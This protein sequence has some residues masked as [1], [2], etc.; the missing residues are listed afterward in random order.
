[1]P[2][3][4]AGRD[5][6]FA[7]DGE[8][9][10]SAE[11]GGAGAGA[12]GGCLPNAT[13][14]LSCS[15]TVG[16][17][18]IACKGI[19]DQCSNAL[20]CP[21]HACIE[22]VRAAVSLGS[23]RLAL[24]AP[25]GGEELRVFRLSKSQGPAVTVGSL[26]LYDWSRAYIVVDPACLDDYLL[27]RFP[28]IPRPNGCGAVGCDL[29]FD[30]PGILAEEGDGEL[31]AWA[32]AEALRQEQWWIQRAVVVL[33]AFHSRA[34][35]VSALRVLTADTVR[36]I[37]CIMRRASGPA[38]EPEPDHSPSQET[39]GTEAALAGP[40]SDERPPLRYPEP[41]Y[42]VEYA[43]P[44]LQ[45]QEAPESSNPTLPSQENYLGVWCV[46]HYLVCFGRIGLSTLLTEPERSLP[47]GAAQDRRL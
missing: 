9:Q 1:V 2:V 24:L 4:S 20:D 13:S 3:A 25:A 29:Y 34:G 14:R 22:V 27:V 15:C 31:L 38:W 43:Y 37:L 41:T 44:E 40:H 45:T 6:S 8:V 47:A 30:H 10:A 33:L 16:V 39:V 46:S 36:L 21:C 12:A 5:A 19:T 23:G 28:S 11:S 42:H 35:A 32:R 26:S 7:G 18:P 17:V